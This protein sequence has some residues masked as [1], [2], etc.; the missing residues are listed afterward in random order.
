MEYINSI[1]GSQGQTQLVEEAIPTLCNRLQHSTMLADRRS[2]VLGLKSFS[3][4][5]RETVVEYGL[6]PL[7]STLK[8]DHNNDNLVKS[9]LETF[10][11]LFIR[12]DSNEDLTRGWISQQLRLQNGKYPSPLLMEGITLDQMS[13]W[14]ADALLQDLEAFKLLVDGL[15]QTDYHLRLYTIQLLESLVASRGIRVKEALLNIPTSISTIC[16][17]LVDMHEP[18]RNEAI[19]LLMAVANN[20]FN[21]QN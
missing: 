9:I 16:N 2:A 21:I 13:L 17:L 4:Q 10:L 3:R 5:Y 14:I 19:L 6:K 7:I 8:K 11:I 1:L 20:N 15:D 18:V 12:G